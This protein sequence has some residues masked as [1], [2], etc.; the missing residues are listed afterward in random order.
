MLNITKCYLNKSGEILEPLNMHKDLILEIFYY[1]ALTRAFDQKAINLQRTGRLGTFP[2]SFGQEAL[3]V[4]AGLALEKTDS[5][6]PYYRDQGAML[7][8]GA[9][10]DRLFAYWAGLELGNDLGNGVFDLP[11]SVPI[12]SQTTHAAGLAY[13]FKYK[14]QKQLVLCSM[15]DGATSK[16]EFYESLNICA[17]HKLPVLFLINN[18]K[19]AIS[20]PLENQS[21]M[22]DLSKKGLS[23][24][25]DGFVVDGHDAIAVYHAVRSLREYCLEAGPAILVADTHR[26]HDHTTADD[27]SRY[28]EPNYLAIGQEHDAIARM[29]KLIAQ[30]Q[31]ARI[32]TKVTDMV[33][34]AVNSYFELIDNTSPFDYTFAKKPACLQQQ[35]HIFE[36]LNA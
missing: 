35:E 33:S 25:I 36:G 11:I 30:E 20:T 26:M 19:Y 14:N 4:S 31:I 5:Y 16:G 23:F 27:A 2:S 34:S 24:G 3:F 18:N 15:G 6:C 1:M 17:I 9:N 32:S 7:A 22:S 29:S 28:L 13:A 12:A 10:M 21:P 8:R